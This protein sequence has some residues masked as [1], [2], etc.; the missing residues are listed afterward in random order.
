MKQ[1]VVELRI[2]LEGK[3]VEDDRPVCELRYPGPPFSSSTSQTINRK[4]VIM[5]N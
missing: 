5:H 2:V 3:V 4:K 1:V